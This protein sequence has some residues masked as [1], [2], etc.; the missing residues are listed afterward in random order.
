MARPKKQPHEKRDQRFNLRYTA[1][2]IEHLRG[3]AERAGLCP[4]DYARKRTL[5]HA[6]VTAK[7]QRTNPALISELN[8]IGV[9]LNQLARMAHLG[10]DFEEGW[11]DLALE[12]QRT[13]QLVMASDG[14]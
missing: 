6:V 11:G 4:H 9:N 1:A 3:Q 13:L 14:A 7:S 2:E 8:R 12:L 5:G 10:K